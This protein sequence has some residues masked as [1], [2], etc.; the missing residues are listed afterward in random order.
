[1]F[2][3][4]QASAC[5]GEAD[6]AA[7]SVAWLACYEGCAPPLNGSTHPVFVE[8]SQ[9]G[10]CSELCEDATGFQVQG[11]DYDLPQLELWY[12]AQ[13]RSCLTSLEACEEASLAGECGCL[14][15][16]SRLQLEGLSSRV[17]FARRAHAD[18]TVP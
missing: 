12:N 14:P 13:L 10:F 3:L 6:D 15:T 5:D 2:V 4:S 17:R 11:N 18:D 16:C 1:M 8:E 9:F 7:R